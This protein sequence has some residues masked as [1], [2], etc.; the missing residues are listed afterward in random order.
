MAAAPPS[1]S[2]KV[3]G[4]PEIELAARRLRGVVR[5]TPLLTLGPGADRPR[6]F[7]KAESL[8]V[9][10]AF[11]VRGAYNAVAAL[12]PEVRRRGVVAASTGNHAIGVAAAAGWRGVPAW[13]VMPA[14]APDV[15][16]AGVLA[17]AAELILGEG[18]S[19]DLKATADAIAWRDGLTVISSYDNADV[20]AGQGTIGLEIVRQV[21]WE[22]GLGGRA[23]GPRSAAAIG[24]LVVMVPLGGGGLASGIA[25]AVQALVPGARIVGVEPEL[26]AKGWS[27]LQAGRLITQPADEVGRTIAD[28]LRVARLG[29][30][31]FEIL[32]SRLD[33]IVRV[34]EGEIADGVR[35]IA[36]GAHLVVEPAG[37]VA[38]AAWLHHRSEL[39]PADLTVC[40]ISGGNV[41]PSSYR[42][43]LAGG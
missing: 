8:Q 27:S 15:K 16:R 20:I 19:D 35:R 24:R 33:G 32:Q 36:F 17:S 14:D 31:P 10:G 22:L 23:R 2:A 21:A 13:I 43:L 28:G 18:S 12:P 6:L 5:E 34:T 25:I 30:L 3:V 29:E 37:A 39:P 4:I 7:L 38:V 11:K 41:D 40:V 1:E 26:A 9:T 42:E